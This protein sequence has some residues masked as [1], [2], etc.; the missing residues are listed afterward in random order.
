MENME[1]QQNY[2]GYKLLEVKACY[3]FVFDTFAFQA[4]HKHNGPL[5]KKP[6]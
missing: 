6:S 5:V 3:I 4:R 1:N 2:V